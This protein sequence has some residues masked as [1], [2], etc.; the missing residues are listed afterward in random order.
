MIA[1]RKTVVDRVLGNWKWPELTNNELKGQIMS[2][3]KKK[4]N[5]HG[6]FRAITYPSLKVSK[7]NNLKKIQW[8][9]ICPYENLSGYV[10]LHQ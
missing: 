1:I 7:Q 5:E 4:M 2:L 3:C 9:K 10:S 6:M 8:A